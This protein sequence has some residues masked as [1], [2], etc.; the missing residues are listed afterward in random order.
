MNATATDR[1][2][3]DRPDERTTFIVETLTDAFADLMEADPDAFRRKFR[4]MAAEPFAFYRGSAPLFYADADARDDRWVDE[5]TSRIWIQG[6]LHAENFGTYMDGSGI[7]VFD[8]NDFD[9]AYLGHWTWDLQRL[10]ASVAL[11]GWSKA[12]PDEV[13]GD[14]IATSVRSYLETVRHLASS[15]HDLD[16]ALRL[17]NTEGPVRTTLLEAQLATRVDLLQA[18]TVVDDYQRRFRHG[19]GKRLLEDDERAVV[20][21]A[22]ERYL[23]TIPESKKFHGPNYAVKDVIGAFGFGIGSAGLPSYNVLIEG[24]TQALENDVVLSMKQGAVPAASRV[25]DDERIRAYFEHQGHRTAVSQRA[26]QAHADPW[27][28]HTEI[29]GTGFVVSELSPYEADLEWDDLTEP[30]Q[31]RPVL[32]ALGQATAKVHCVADADSDQTLV[33]FQTEDA[34]IKVVGDRDDELVDDILTF[35]T[36]ASPASARPESRGPG[37]PELAVHVTSP[38]GAEDARPADH[39]GLHRPRRRRLRRQPRRGGRAARPRRRP[40]HH[41]LRRARPANLRRRRRARR[42]RRRSG[43]AGRRRHPQLRPAPRAPLRRHRLGAR[44]RADQLPPLPR[45]GRLHPRALRIVGPP[46]GPRARRAARRARRRAP[47]SPR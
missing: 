1:P 43:R 19:P 10:A 9:E 27:L 23:D 42:A 33:D 28:G 5:R 2:D 14:L 25:V 11:M 3:G 38:S 15:E 40:R 21:D 34:I 35:A 39:P 16:F 36:G 8:V 4:K 26:L 31:M 44:P 6:D 30:D 29:G 45:R 37:R 22:F 20:E 32:H 13:I 17:D 18:D 47:L 24:H 7:L 12:L 41:D 46:P